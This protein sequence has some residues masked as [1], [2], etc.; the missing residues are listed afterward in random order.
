MKKSW[1][2]VLGLSLLLG[3]GKKE[4]VA[5]LAAF[6][7]Y[8]EPFL[9]LGFSH[10]QG[11][12]LQQDGAKIAFY[13]SADGIYKFNPLSIEGKDAARVIVNMEKMDTLKTLDEFVRGLANDLSASGFEVSSPVEKA[14]TDIPGKLVHYRGALDSKTIITGDEVVAMKDSMMYTIVFEGFNKMYAGYKAVLDT[15]LASLHLPAPKVVEAGVDPA[16]PSAEFET[17]ENDYLKITYPIN[18]QPTPASVKEPVTFALT[19]YGYRRDSG[20]F[21]DVRPAQGLTPEKVVEQNAAKV[22]E[23]GRGTATI[24]GVQTTWL[25]YSGG[26]DISSRIYFL[27]KNDKFYRIIVNYYQPMKGDFLPVFE[28]MV[29]S[30]VTK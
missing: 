6:E 18:F 15:V 13:S 1:V 26:K 7:K 23:T 24:D 16:I 27:V 20:I 19:I 25:N 21:V 29:A 28:K 11:W 9:R 2:L 3:C 5:P 10:P 30:I 14:V 22:K 17:F 8:Q 4:Q 12:Q